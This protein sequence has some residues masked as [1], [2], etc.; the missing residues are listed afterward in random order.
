FPRYDRQQ[1]FEWHQ[2]LLRRL[3]GAAGVEVRLSY[4][5]VMEGLSSKPAAIVGELTDSMDENQGSQDH[6]LHPLFSS[7]QSQQ[8]IDK[9]QESAS[10][11]L[12]QDERPRGGTS[13]IQNQAICPFRAFAIHRLGAEELRTPQYG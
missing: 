3:S 7:L 9:T 13:L 4:T 2:Q 10:L 1:H 6:Q 5:A 11:P 12:Q 8:V